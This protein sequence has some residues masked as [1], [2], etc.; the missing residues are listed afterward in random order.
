MTFNKARV[1][2]DKSI[3]RYHKLSYIK[4]SFPTT[5]IRKIYSTSLTNYFF[6]N[7]YITTMVLRHL[8]GAPQQE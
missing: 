4:P 5:N 2:K 7:I 6:L 8:L 3:K 1:L